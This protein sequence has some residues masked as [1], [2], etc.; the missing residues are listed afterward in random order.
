[1]RDFFQ[2]NNVMTVV[3]DLYRNCD[4][5]ISDQALVTSFICE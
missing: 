4:N 2:L 3:E 5:M 1:M